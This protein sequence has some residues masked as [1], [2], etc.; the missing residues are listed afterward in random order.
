MS[1]AAGFDVVPPTWWIDEGPLGEGSA[2]LWIEDAQLDLVD[3]VL[4]ERIPA[5]WLGM[6]IGADEKQRPVALVHA[7]HPALRRLSLFD[8]MVNNADRKGGHVLH[9]SGDADVV[10]G[11]DHGLTFHTDDKLRTVLWGWADEGFTAD[12]LA[13]LHRSREV[14]EVLEPWL[15]AGEIEATGARIDRLITEGTFPEPGE[16]WPIIPWPPL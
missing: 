9:R 2:Q 15:A 13:L 14:L 16:R 6:V 5:D 1:R 7:D 4:C 3:L 10:L 8:A 12:E 11:C